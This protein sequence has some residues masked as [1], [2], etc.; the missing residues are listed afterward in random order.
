MLGLILFEIVLL[1]LFILAFFS[2]SPSS[3]LLKFLQ[4]RYWHLIYS[5]HSLIPQA[6]YTAT[7][8]NT[9]YFEYNIHSQKSFI[10]SV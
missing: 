7:V 9:A 1:F 2:I 5:R 10:E 4:S 8:A 3:Y 6:Q